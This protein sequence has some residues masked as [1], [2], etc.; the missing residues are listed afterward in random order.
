MSF[1]QNDWTL[2]VV[3]MNNIPSFVPSDGRNESPRV[4]S[5]EVDAISTLKMA[6]SIFNC[7]SVSG[8]FSPETM[9]EKATLEVVAL[10]IAAVAV[11]VVVDEL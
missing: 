1:I 9:V 11:L 8:G 2:P 6:L 10:E 3:K 4:C 7:S 5:S